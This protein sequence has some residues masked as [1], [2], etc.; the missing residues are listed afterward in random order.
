MWSLV[1]KYSAQGRQIIQ[2]I[3]E[4]ITWSRYRLYIFTC[5]IKDHSLLFHKRLCIVLSFGLVDLTP[6]IPWDHKGQFPFIH[7]QITWSRGTFW[8]VCKSFLRICKS[9]VCLSIFF[10]KIQLH[11]NHKI[12]RTKK[13]NNSERLWTDHVIQM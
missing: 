8:N 7:E 10:Q 3:C 13:G 9:S 11:I 5:H 12:Q 6:R 1:T 4:H 2:N